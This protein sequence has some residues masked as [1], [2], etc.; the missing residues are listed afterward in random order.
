MKAIVV[1]GGV[2]G[3][4]ISLELARSGLQVTVVDRGGLGAEASTAAAG[5]LAPQGE[6]S[7][8]GPMLDAM[9][10]S[11]A[12]YPQWAA[13]LEAASGLT[14][15]Y[16]PSGLLQVAFDEAQV[17]A[18]EAQVAWQRAS[19]LRAEWLSASQARAQVPALS[20]EAQAAALFEDDHQVDPLRLMPALIEAARR[21]S[22]S[23]Q[24]A[25]VKGL[26][27]SIGRV[28]G[29]EVEGG[30]LYADVVVVAA[31]PW[32]GQFISE[33]VKPAR[34]QMAELRLEAP[35]FSHMLKTSGGYL[36]PRADGRVIA[37]STVELV[38]FDKGVTSEGVEAILRVARRLV[39]ALGGVE[40]HSTWAGL[41][42]LCDDALPI[43]GEGAMAGVVVATGHFRNGILLAPLT[44]RTVGQIVRGE[45][46]TLDVNPFRA[47]RFST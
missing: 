32:S 26:A 13:Q 36:V 12:M 7:G 18:L 28:T 43:L 25:D 40:V 23:F 11:R 44:A 9:L 5:M 20:G 33:T 16:L 31:G 37:G 1:G 42:P 27:S 46:P 6:A 35:V 39:P 10:R 34:G 24:V 41:R 14:V 21:A 19:G 15:G 47:S 22:V 38:G 29:V 17:H 45:K 3:C 8:P 4:S 30:L 2:I